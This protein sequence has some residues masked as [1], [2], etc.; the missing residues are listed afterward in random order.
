MAS[1]S[2]IFKWWSCPVFKWQYSNGIQPLF[3]HFNTERVWC[4][5]PSCFKLIS[6]DKKHQKLFILPHTVTI[7][8]FGHIRTHCPDLN[9]QLVFQVQVMNQPNF[10]V[11]ARTLRGQEPEQYFIQIP[12][13]QLIWSKTEF[14]GGDKKALYQEVG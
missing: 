4:S 5:D 10:M 7:L 3:N 13:L 14:G 8:N 2:T 12:F 1:I 6:K 9:T 11:I